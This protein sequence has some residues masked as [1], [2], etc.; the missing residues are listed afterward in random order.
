MWLFQ[1]PNNVLDI[2]RLAFACVERPDALVEF[3]VWPIGS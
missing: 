3:R 1:S 2:E